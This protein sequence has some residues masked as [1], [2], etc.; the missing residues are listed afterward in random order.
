MNNA[1]CQENNSPSNLAQ[2]NRH[3]MTWTVTQNTVHLC[4]I[5]SSATIL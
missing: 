3:A 1:K 4:C 2:P 5:L